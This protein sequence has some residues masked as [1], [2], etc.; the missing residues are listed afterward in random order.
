M[1]AIYDRLMRAPSRIILSLLSAWKDDQKHWFERNIH[2]QVY[3]PNTTVRAIANPVAAPS[4][5]VYGHADGNGMA[6]LGSMRAFF[7]E[8]VHRHHLPPGTYDFYHTLGNEMFMTLFGAGKATRAHESTQRGKFLG[9]LPIPRRS[10]SEHE[11]P[12]PATLEEAL[13]IH[14]AVIA[15]AFPMQ[16]R[17]HPEGGFMLLYGDAL[18]T[19]EPEM[20]KKF[21][22]RDPSIPEGFTLLVRKVPF[23]EAMDW[24]CVAVDNMG[25]IINFEEKPAD[26]DKGKI[27]NEEEAKLWRAH[28]K[29]QPEDELNEMARRSGLPT[30]PE[31][32]EKLRHELFVRGLLVDDQFILMNTA[33][34]VAGTGTVIRLLQLAGARIDAKGS[35]VVDT[36]SVPPFKPG[37]PDG[38]LSQLQATLAGFLI[39][40]DSP[41]HIRE[42]LREIDEHLN[43]DL[44]ESHRLAKSILKL[45]LEYLG[46]SPK[47]DRTAAKLKNAIVQLSE[48]ISV[49]DGLIR[50]GL[51]LDAMQQII[52]K[53]TSAANLEQE[54]F[55]RP[56]S[57]LKKQIDEKEKQKTRIVRHTRRSRPSL[58][59]QMPLQQILAKLRRR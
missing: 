22:K 10:Q 13:A 2:A 23:E 11:S 4:Q 12:Q 35:F 48:P 27:F 51:Q 33:I 58:D 16:V 8:F 9:L 54:V 53:M 20:L 43:P 39:A 47:E 26:P 41:D 21:F 55:K 31:L 15:D 57:D 52:P 45:L 18:V 42:R 1:R 19:V 38:A 14:A 36:E 25:R 5:P 46:E 29:G 24:G 37:D 30:I 34:G 32:K 56:L 6:V 3:P 50:D 7:A 44:G 28:L 59:G 49:I 17:G 40:K